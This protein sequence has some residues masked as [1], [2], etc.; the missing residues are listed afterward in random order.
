LIEGQIPA[1]KKRVYLSAG[2]IGGL[3]ICSRTK[4]VY[5]IDN[6]KQKDK[7]KD[8]FNLSLLRYGFTARAG[9]RALRFYATYYPTSL[10]MEGKGPE[11]YPFSV[12]LTLGS[13]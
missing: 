13:F 10:F 7:I 9:Y 11:L 2:V 1:G 12:G 8:D 3:K 6:R 4:M 5:E